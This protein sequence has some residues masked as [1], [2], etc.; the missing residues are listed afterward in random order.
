M[1]RRAG[2]GERGRVRNPEA[3]DEVPVQ[4]LPPVNVLQGQTYL[5]ENIHDLLL[6]ERPPRLLPPRYG[7]REVATV[8]VIHHDVQYV[9][10]RGV[11]ERL[12]VRANVRV[13]HRREDGSLGY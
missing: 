1:G 7:A 2:S 13:V 10:L 5:N 8:G 3:F 12:N 6:A 11:E 9:V 4:D